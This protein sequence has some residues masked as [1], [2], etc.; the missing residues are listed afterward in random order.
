MDAVE[1]RR[2]KMSMSD[3][4]TWEKLK[5]REWLMEH[6]EQEV[7]PLLIR[8]GEEEYRRIAELY[9]EIDVPLLE[10]HVRRA[11]AHCNQ[12]IQE[13]GQDF[14]TCAANSAHGNDNH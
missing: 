1:L 6:I 11:L 8:G 2:K 4:S 9:A 13:V 12:D 5:N 7:T 10:R 3:L 14:Q